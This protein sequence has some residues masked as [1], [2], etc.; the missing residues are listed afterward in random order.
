MSIGVAITTFKT[1]L[2]KFT[3]RGRFS[4][5]QKFL[6]KFQHLV[7]SG[8]HN[9]AMITDQRLQIAGN[10]LP[11]DNSTGCLVSIFIV[12]INSNYFPGPCVPY[13]KPPQYFGN[14]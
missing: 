14:V 13:K 7:T 6:T 9:Y 4:K 10:S 5:K 2:Q 3:V 12:G 1:E 11:N 8:H